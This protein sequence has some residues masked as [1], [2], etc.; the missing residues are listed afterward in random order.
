MQSKK[1]SI[2]LVIVIVTVAGWFLSVKAFL[3][4]DNEKAQA[5]LVQEADGYASKELYVRAIPTYR[6]ALVYDVGNNAEIEAKLLNAYDLYGDMVSYVKLAEKRIAD[7]T[8]A[9]Q[10]YIRTADYYRSTNKLSDAMEIVR[11]GIGQTGS[12]ALRNYYEENRYG[13]KTR[14]VSYEIVTPTYE[15]TIMPAYDGEK[16]VYVDENGRDLGIGRFDT[17]VPFND[18]GYAVVSAGGKYQ[19]ILTNGDLYGIDETGM[20]DVQAVSGSRVLAR[21]KGKY[22][23]YNF[24]FQP[25][26]Q[27]GHQYDQMTSNNNG[28][29]AVRSGDQWGIITDGG[30][31]VVDFT[32]ADV[33][34]NSI[35]NAFSGG[36]AMVKDNNG[37]YLADTE[38]NR[39]N[40]QTYAAAKA[41][42]SPGGY[43]AVGNSNGKWGFADLEGN[44]VIDYK[45]DDAYSFSDGVAAVCVGETW[46]Y[47]SAQGR[48]VID[49]SLDG[50][51]PFHSGRAQAHF[52]DG[53]ILIRLEYVEK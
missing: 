42:E 1:L 2:I 28:V 45:Y 8:A 48:T 12:D 52:V 6:E 34:V 29:A 37:W 25:L 39:L 50:A 18:N 33:A 14:V 49:Y 47:I 27:G 19:T 43:I 21:Y 36:H 46:T 11:T 22:S 35:G 10:E 20:E 16:W 15:N 51:Q 17:A 41:P 3:G 44:L 23:Y 9:E 7:N 5:Q 13:C 31:T 24:D 26:T 30:G 40:D 32:L 53:T 38:G 4:V